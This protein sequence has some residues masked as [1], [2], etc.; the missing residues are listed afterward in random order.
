[1]KWD[2][3]HIHAQTLPIL[4][5]QTEISPRPDGGVAL[6]STAQLLSCSTFL[7]RECERAQTAG[8]TISS[9]A[10]LFS[11]A[12]G[13]RVTPLADFGFVFG[14]PIAL[15]VGLLLIAGGRR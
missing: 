2:I 13:E 9:S 12:Q 11:L 14:V 3:C 7:A 4:P 1:M 10:L 8:L 5:W 15:F 6:S